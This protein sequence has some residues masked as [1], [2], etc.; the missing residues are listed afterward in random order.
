[1]AKGKNVKLW[2][3]HALLNATHLAWPNVITKKKLF[4]SVLK[5]MG[6]GFTEEE[7]KAQYE[8][9]KWEK[10]VKELY[11]YSAQLDPQAIQGEI[12]TYIAS[13][14]G[15]KAPDVESYLELTTSITRQLIDNLVNRGEVVTFYGDEYVDPE[16]E[17][18][19]VPQEAS[20]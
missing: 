3:R 16:E 14:S 9:L 7:V 11:E 2:V 18:Y 12:L 20:E 5:A 15:V 10:Y 6:I 4:E 19:H 17:V 13:K 8:K 1:M